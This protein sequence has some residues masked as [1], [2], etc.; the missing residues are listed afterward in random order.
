M[1]Q[2]AEPIAER[3][4]EADEGH[5]VPEAGGAGD[6]IAAGFEG[7]KALGDG[8]FLIPQQVQ[9][10]HGQHHV[11]AFGGEVHVFDGADLKAHICRA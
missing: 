6:E 7:L 3:G 10:G 11:E 8:G 9:D 4:D 2:E 5:H 1:G